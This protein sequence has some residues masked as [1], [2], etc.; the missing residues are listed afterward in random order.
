M[1]RRIKS[2]RIRQEGVALLAI[3]ILAGI[4]MLM[5]SQISYRHQLDKSANA[6]SMVQDQSILLALSAESWARRILRDDA[7]NNQTDSLLDDWA[8]PIP[9]LP[10]EGGLLMGCLV[11]MQSKFNLNNLQSYDTQSWNESISS[12]SSSNLDAYLNL[13]AILE[14]DSSDVRAAVIV[15]WTDADSE[16][17]LAGSAENQDYMLDIPARL[18][19]NRP[20]TS[21]E[22][23]AAL[24]GYSGFDVLLLYPYATVLPSAT[25]V[26]VNTASPE[27]LTALSSVMDRFLVDSILEQ[28][29]FESLDEFYTFV[30]DGS[31]YM[32]ET[33]L[34]A[35]LPE[36]M[37]AV[38]SQY[39]ELLTT[40][41]LLDQELKMRSLIYRN[42][43]EAS[44]FMREF[45]MVPAVLSERAE[46]MVSTFDCVLPAANQTESETSGLF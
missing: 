1:A 8:Y 5:V 32:T 37:L 38:A 40:V 12:L 33:E 27:V 24:K 16:T 39:F 26:N 45:Q 44:V 10:V 42:G 14:Q 7:E 35:Q 18:S 43:A 13:L 20:L 3:I 9:P 6:R 36:S 31:G 19:A 17:L 21:I 46:G 28:R 15:D 4:C 11:D 34:K 22:E 25:G 30:A 29:P 41:S 23:L 2:P